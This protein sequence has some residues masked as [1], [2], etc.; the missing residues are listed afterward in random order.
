MK[1]GCRSKTANCGIALVVLGV[2][3]QPVALPQAAF[4]APLTNQC[5]DRD[6]LNALLSSP[7]NL[8]AAISHAQCAVDQGDF[9]SAVATLE[10]LLI[11]TPEN[12]QLELDL[13]DL[14]ARLGSVE[15]ARAHYQNVLA[16]GGLSDELQQ[17]AESGLAK[18]SS[19]GGDS[20][21]FT[22][23]AAWRWQ[24]NANLGLSSASILVGSTLVTIP[25]NQTKK[26][27]SSMWHE[28]GLSARLASSGS[29][30]DVVDA[31]QLDVDW[32]GNWQDK[33]KPLDSILI[34]AELGPE[35]SLTAFDTTV[36]PYV[37]LAYSELEEKPL[38]RS[39]GGGVHIYRQISDSLT[40]E[41]KLDYKSY[42]YDDNSLRTLSTS[43]DGEQF[44][45]TSSL[46]Y[47][48]NDSWL[49][50]A[51]THFTFSDLADD[52]YSY[53][54]S[55]ISI[56]ATVDTG[57]DPF[58]AGSVALDFSAGFETRD[59][60]DPSTT[61]P[62]VTRADEQISLGFE[63]DMPLTNGLSLVSRIEYDQVDSNDPFS[64]YDAITT[65]L[66]LRVSQ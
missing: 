36:R 64:N 4:G 9:E 33:A 47:L 17:R 51:N 37:S 63:A 30:N 25:N 18:L 32:F 66:G 40:L 42:R 24:D 5:Q 43:Y 7:G 22:H 10:G 56:G 31:W 27:D 26:S 21:T 3:F 34:S 13:A 29:L 46:T 14:Y 45:S 41:S 50:S 38:Y 15:L 6:A 55:G 11:Y 2:L 35:F 57:W 59:H 61:A 28:G 49:L 54:G 53:R 23:F 16:L 62:F 58:E 12:A 20:F 44:S 48:V 39:W 19:A 60:M 8:D 65:Y 52:Q 1:V